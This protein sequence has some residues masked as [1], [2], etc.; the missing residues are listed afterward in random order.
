MSLRRFVP[1]VKIVLLHL[2]QLYPYTEEAGVLIGARRQ[3]NL[4]PSLADI[5]W[6]EGDEE[7]D[8]GHFDRPR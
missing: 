4:V 7:D 2:L 8:E 5:A 1:N 6:I 3:T